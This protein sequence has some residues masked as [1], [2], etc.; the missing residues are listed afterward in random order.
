MQLLLSVKSNEYEQVADIS[1]WQ[2]Q[3]NYANK[4]H[5]G[6]FANVAMS[7]GSYMKVVNYLGIFFTDKGKKFSEMIL[8]VILLHD[9][10]VYTVT[11]FFF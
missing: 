10:K 6:K 5:H 2:W 11:V 7:K 9:A 1:Q 8:S 3:I 4:H